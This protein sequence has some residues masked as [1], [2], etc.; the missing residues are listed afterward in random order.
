ML[1][2]CTQISRTQILR[3]ATLAT[4]YSNSDLCLCHI[5]GHLCAALALNNV[6]M[7]TVDVAQ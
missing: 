7:L 1:M 6:Y 2:H 3:E 5:T 4:D